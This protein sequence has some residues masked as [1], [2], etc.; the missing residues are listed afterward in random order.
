MKAP[1]MPDVQPLYA[2]HVLYAPEGEE[3]GCG[4]IASSSEILLICVFG[5]QQQYQGWYHHQC[6]RVFVVRGWIVVP[7]ERS[8]MEVLI[9]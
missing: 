5:D 2:G 9:A 6:K 8:L 7:F 1:W 4:C 3:M